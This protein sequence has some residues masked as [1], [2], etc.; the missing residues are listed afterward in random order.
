[1]VSTAWRQ[2]GRFHALVAVNAK[3]PADELHAAHAPV[4]ATLGPLIERG[5]R[6]GSFRADVPAAWHLRMILALIHAASAAVSAE[7]GAPEDVERALVP[8]VL[9][10]VAT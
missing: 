5:Q 4:L 10:A 8:T 2:L 6:D 7:D 9:G 3:L 1:V